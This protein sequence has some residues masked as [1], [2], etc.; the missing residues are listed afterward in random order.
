MFPNWLYILEERHW[1][2]LATIALILALVSLL[3]GIVQAKASILGRI[4][5]IIDIALLVVLAIKLVVIIE[6]KVH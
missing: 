5:A 6:R 3:I 1:P 4:D 2:S